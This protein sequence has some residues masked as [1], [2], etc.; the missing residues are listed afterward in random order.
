MNDDPLGQDK[1]GNDVYLRDLWPSNDDI[2]KVVDQVI[3]AEMFRERYA[4][5]FKGTSEWQAIKTS[6]GLTFDWDDS[7]TYVQNP[8]YFQ[9][10]GMEP[11]T[12]ENVEGAKVLAI[13]GD[14]ITTDHIS[15]AGAFK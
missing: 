9:G 10:M 7:S 12:I 15:P 8:P 1:D 14:M 13:L 2:R 4:D 6:T 5:V 3:S 11:G